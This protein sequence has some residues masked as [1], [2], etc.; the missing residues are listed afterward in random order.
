MGAPSVTVQVSSQLG[1]ANRVLFLLR[2]A[3]P[4]KHVV[5]FSRCVFG[6]HFWRDPNEVVTHAKGVAPY[7]YDGT[8]IVDDRH[9]EAGNKIVFFAFR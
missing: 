2:A 5:A 4:E 7:S 3:K 8:D 1:T 9:T 6:P